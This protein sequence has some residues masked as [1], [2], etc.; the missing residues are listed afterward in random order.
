MKKMLALFLFLPVL[1]AAQGIPIKD[2]SGSSLAK[3]NALGSVQVN[4]GPSSRPTYIASA[5]GLVTTAL[6]NMSIE[7]GASIGFKISQVCVGVSN[8]TAAAL[9]TVTVQRRTTAST[10]GTAMTNEGTASPTISRMDQADGT[11]AG[12]GKVT[13][14]LGT[15]GA[16]LDQWGFTV[17][18]LG[19]GTADGA[20]PAVYCKMY[21][22][23]GEKLPTAPSGATNGISVNVSAPGAGGLAAGSISMTLI[24][25]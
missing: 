6:F 22:L 11:W 23:N 15:A 17:G 3:V 4:E 14:T 5:G 2:G 12:L 8:A 25:E 19:A 20:G 9:V 21:G 1:A 13:A 16:I 18:E 7:S 10:G 24:A